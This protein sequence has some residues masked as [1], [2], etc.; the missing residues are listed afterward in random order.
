MDV[1]LAGDFDVAEGFKDFAVEFR[2]ARRS[3][4]RTSDD[5]SA[6]DAEAVLRADPEM[7]WRRYAATPRCRRNRRLSTAGARGRR[8]GASPVDGA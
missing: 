5:D 2:A 1:E 4:H 3:F 6:P 7:Y 8:P